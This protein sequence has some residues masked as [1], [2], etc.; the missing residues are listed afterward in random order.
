MLEPAE[1]L[2]ALAQQQLGQVAARLAGDPCDQRLRLAH[3]SSLGIRTIVRT[4]RR[5]GK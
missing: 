4:F 1:D 3:G 2:V 5:L